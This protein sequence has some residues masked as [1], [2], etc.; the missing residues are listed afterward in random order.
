MM[1][2]MTS[3]WTLKGLKNEKEMIVGNFKQTSDFREKEL[4]AMGKSFLR[5]LDN[6]KEEGE[7]M[8]HSIDEGPYKRKH[9]PHPN[10]D[11]KT[12]LEPIS[13][14]S[15]QKQNR[16]TP[17]STSRQRPTNG[18]SPSALDIATISWISKALV[19]LLFSPLRLHGSFS[20]PLSCKIQL[21]T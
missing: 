2:V 10:E 16:I 3:W 6:K 15:S 5:F 20:R 14:M 18:Q 8:R 4:C 1:I 19:P 21:H 11:T 12:I 9:I 7:L 13:K 17:L